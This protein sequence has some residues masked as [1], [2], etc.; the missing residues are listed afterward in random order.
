MTLSDLYACLKRREGAKLLTCVYVLMGKSLVER[1]RQVHVNTGGS[2]SNDDVEISD[3]LPG[4]KDN[5]RRLSPSRK[6]L[7]ALETEERDALDGTL[8]VG[9]CKIALRGHESDHHLKPNYSRSR[10]DWE[11]GDSKGLLIR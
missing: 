2:D 6:M 3:L 9:F 1:S 5:S 11:S 7:P 4:K 10:E 8:V